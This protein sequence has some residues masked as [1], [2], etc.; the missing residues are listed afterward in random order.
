MGRWTPEPV[1]CHV[2]SEGLLFAKN[3]AL[4][5]SETLRKEAHHADKRC[6]GLLRA[7]GQ[8]PRPS[9][10]PVCKVLIPATTLFLELKGLSIW[11]GCFIS[12]ASVKREWGRTANH[13]MQ[14]SRYG[15]SGRSGA[16]GV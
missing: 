11:I 3:L 13:N 10:L 14:L 9:R 4:E 5:S 16:F 12:S 15:Q 2:G 7:F 8:S 1:G 6:G